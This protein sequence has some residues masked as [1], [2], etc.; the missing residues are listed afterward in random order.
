MHANE[1]FDSI[2]APIHGARRGLLVRATIGQSATL[3]LR[4]DG[5]A[6]RAA[7]LALLHRLSAGIEAG[8]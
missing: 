2:T 8:W 3:H 5:R 4:D 7:V 1:V 6:G